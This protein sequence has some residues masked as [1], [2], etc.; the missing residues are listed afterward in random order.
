MEENEKLKK[1]LNFFQHFDAVPLQQE[2]PEDTLELQNV[3][4]KTSYF[5]LKSILFSGLSRLIKGEK[6]TKFHQIWKKIS[7]SWE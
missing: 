1:F 5:I 3:I 6:S 2:I 7:R 4:F